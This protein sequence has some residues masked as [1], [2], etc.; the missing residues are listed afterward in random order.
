MTAVT[1][2]YDELV[3]LLGKSVTREEIEERLP[4]MGVAFDGWEGDS[5]VLDV[6]ANHPDWYSVEGL[7][8]SLRGF[9][10]IETGLQGYAVK[11]SGVD[12]VVEKGV[13]RVRPFAVGG[14]VRGLALGDALL[15]SVID[16]QEKLH[17]TIG[18]KRK[19]V[20]IGIH[21]A[22]K[23]TPPFTYRAVDPHAVRF[24]PLGMDREL[25]LAQVLAEHEKGR[26]Y[27]AALAGAEVYPVIQDARGA[28][29]SFPPIINGVATQLTPETRNLFVDVTGTDRGS[30]EVVLNILVTALADRGG[31]LESV[32]LVTPEGPRE[33]PDL[34]PRPMTLDLAYAGGLTGIAL[35]TKDVIAALTRLR[36]DVTAKGGEVTALVP[37]YR[38]DILHVV[39]VV[40]DIAVGYGYERI[41]PRLPAHAT[42]GRPAPAQETAALL[43]TLLQGYGYQEV[44]TLPLVP[45]REP[46][47]TE[48]RAAVRNPISDE[49]ALVRSA[50]LPGLLNLLRANKHRDLPQ[51]VFEVGAVV[52]GGANA[53]HAAAAS[54]H[55]K[56]GFTEVKSLVQSLLRDLGRTWELAGADDANYLPGRCAAV[57]VDGQERGRFGEVH[58]SVLAGYELRHP[59]VAFEVDAALGG[60]R[61]R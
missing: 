51:R 43:R 29:L 16:L 9:L 56:A 2:G 21:D 50:L 14:I 30:V 11:P 20:A 42:P 61:E 45:R 4:M 22:D 19:K 48:G 18:R 38:A 28:V 36:Y 27:A 33:T 6:F 57:V 8:R 31:V 12:F 24:V 17:T 39:D 54:V 35:T 5:L 15:R 46:F 23:V 44:W 60:S 10:G 55:A 25:D 1:V 7:A 37:A 13:E 32:R 3:G 34:S 41:R 58:P 52:V 53:L 40:E 47:A 26:E 59:V 49:V